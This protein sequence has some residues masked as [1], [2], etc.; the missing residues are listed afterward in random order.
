MSTVIYCHRSCLNI[1][2]CIF[3][4]YKLP[5]KTDE[6]FVE[7]D[8]KRWFKTGDVGEVHDDGVVTIIGELLVI[9]GYR[10]VILI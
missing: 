1:Q 7:A 3:R 8:G 2:L 10:L 4:Y 5:G 6:D 9:S